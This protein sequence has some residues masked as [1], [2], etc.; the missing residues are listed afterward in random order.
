[1]DAAQ[2]ALSHTSASVL[3][4]NHGQSHGLSPP[5]RMQQL[6]RAP[7]NSAMMPQYSQPLQRHDTIILNENVEHERGRGRE[8]MRMLSP[9]MSNAFGRDGSASRPPSRDSR[10]M[11]L[12]SAHAHHHQRMQGAGA[13]HQPAHREPYQH[14]R[15]PT[16]PYI[17]SISTKE[18]QQ[19]GSGGTSNDDG[20]ADA[21]GDGDGD[22]DQDADADADADPDADADG[23][24]EFDVDGE[25]V[26]TLPPGG[27]SVHSTPAT[28]SPK[29]QKQGHPQQPDHY[30]PHRLSHPHAH[31]QSAMNLPPRRPHSNSNSTDSIAS[32]R[33]SSESV[34]GYNNRLSN[35]AAPNGLA[36]TNGHGNGYLHVIGVNGKKMNHH[37]GEDVDM[38]V[39][40]EADADA[41]QDQDQDVDADE[42]DGVGVPGV[43]VTLVKQE[44]V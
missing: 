28:L 33:N 36:K 1:M 18:Q 37:A 14:R 9:G 16:P 4:Q 12:L 24:G 6:G 20:D 3:A 35:G 15:L 30:S 43:S 21:D 39:S 11:P 27:A 8:R 41:D 29:G 44:A 25:L 13:H 38:D 10:G 19:Y 32:S 5:N 23:D 26:G 42:M 22:A 40:M 2:A 17:N 7:A 31:Q 34:A